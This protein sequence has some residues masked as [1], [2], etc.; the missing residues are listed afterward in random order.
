[1]IKTTILCETFLTITITIQEHLGQEHLYT[2]L[3]QVQT[4]VLP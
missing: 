1:M 4:W 2:M 3:T